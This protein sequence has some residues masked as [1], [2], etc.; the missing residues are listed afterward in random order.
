MSDF[1]GSE[2]AFNECL[3]IDI[4]FSTNP[5]DICF[6]TVFNEKGA[7]IENNSF[8]SKTIRLLTRRDELST[9]PTLPYS[10]N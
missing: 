7:A 3:G 8:L 6:I 2:K 1:W 5:R 4:A 9:R 10:S